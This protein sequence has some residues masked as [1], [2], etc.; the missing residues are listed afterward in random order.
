MGGPQGIVHKGRLDLQGAGGVAVSEDHGGL[1]GGGASEGVGGVVAGKG[2]GGVEELEN[3]L[4]DRGVLGTD[5]SDVTKRHGVQRSSGR[6]RKE[7]KKERKGKKVFSTSIFSFFILF[8]EILIF[9]FVCGS[10]C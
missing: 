2:V 10:A 4:R 7:W 9:H 5:N 3:H 8:F 6:R 1:E